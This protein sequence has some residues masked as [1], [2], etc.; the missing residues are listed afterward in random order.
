[1]S[2]VV[3]ISDVPFGH[4]HGLNQSAMSISGLA[5]ILYCDV[6]YVVV[7]F[8]SLCGRVHAVG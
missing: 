5:T 6:L 1:M 7:L 3:L 4:C 8:V 2:T